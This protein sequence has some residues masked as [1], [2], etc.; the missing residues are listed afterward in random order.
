ML[1]GESTANDVADIT[2]VA[3]TPEQLSVQ[4]A[5]L[6]QQEAKQADQLLEQYKEMKEMGDGIDAEQDMAKQHINDQLDE[7]KRKV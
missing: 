6:E 3:M 2:K 7:Q 4:Q 5:L 1:H